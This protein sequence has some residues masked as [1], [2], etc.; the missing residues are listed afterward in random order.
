MLFMAKLIDPT[1]GSSLWPTGERR[2]PNEVLK[3]KSPEVSSSTA[4]KRLRAQAVRYWKQ[5]LIRATRQ[6]PA[7]TVGILL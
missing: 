5:E 1:A 2:A 3:W 7:E 4:Q 6:R